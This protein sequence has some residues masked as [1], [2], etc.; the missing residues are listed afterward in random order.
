MLKNVSILIALGLGLSSCNASDEILEKEKMFVATATHNVIIKLN[1]IKSCKED[2]FSTPVKACFEDL[3]KKV[4][5]INI[6]DLEDFGFR[7]S[8][9]LLDNIT[10]CE[11]GKDIK[12]ITMEDNI[13]KIG[14]NETVENVTSKK[15][16]RISSCYQDKEKNTILMELSQSH[17]SPVQISFEVAK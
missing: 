7:D 3:N 15:E 1:N 5:Y 6:N 17:T 11:K 14:E 2:N 16:Q 9:L 12:Y 10:L 8:I 4:L 13:Q